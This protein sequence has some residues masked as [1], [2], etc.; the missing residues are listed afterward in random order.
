[1]TNNEDL[2]KAIR[3]VDSSISQNTSSN[4]N[5]RLT[6]YLGFTFTIIIQSCRLLDQLSKDLQ[7]NYEATEK[8]EAQLINLNS[9][10]V[11]GGSCRYLGE[12]K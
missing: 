10:L 2:E 5:S 4:T 7:R 6:Y 1:M 11:R 9:N 3:D 12:D 8:V